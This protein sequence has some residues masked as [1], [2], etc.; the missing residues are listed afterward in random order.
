MAW[1]P[2]PEASTVRILFLT[3]SFNSLAQRLYV[4]LAARGHELSVEL[5]INDVATESAAALFRPQLIVAPFLK[6]AIPESVWGRHVC[7]VVHPGI[8]GDR[9][10]SAL[11]WAILEGKTHWGVTVLQ[12]EREMDAGPVWA[13]REFPMRCAPKSSLYRFEVTEA[14]VAAVLEA[15]ER[16]AGG[17]F[18]PEPVDPAD[19]EI[20]GRWRE[21][22]KQAQRTIDWARDDTVTVLRKIHSADGYP[23]VRDELAGLPVRLYDTHPEGRLA[24][25][26]GALLARRDGAVCRATVDGAVWIGRLRRTD[27]PGLKL[28][29]VDVLGEVGEA[30]PESRLESGTPLDYPTYREIRYEERKDVGFLHFDFHNGAMG[31]AQCRRLLEAWRHAR[32]RPTRVIVLLGGRDFW[33][34]G[35]HLNLIEAAPSPAD[36]SWHNINAMDDLAEAVVRTDGQLTISALGANAGAGGAFLAL[37]ADR[38]IARE[39]IVLNPH[40]KNMGNLYGSELWTYLLPR[41]VGAAGVAAVMAHRLPLAAGEA[42][43]MGVVDEVGPGDPA[44]F[45]GAVASSAAKL[46]AGPDFAALLAA[47]RQRRAADEGLKPLADYRAEELERMKL[48]F[49]GFDP[50]YHVARYR[51]VHRTPHAWTPL[52]LAAHRRLGWQLPRDDAA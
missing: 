49:Y 48:N 30:L 26:P 13:W 17:V 31:T 25:P 27:E 45:R 44:A 52:Y 3:H 32:A 47:K 43:A 4:E 40:Y 9:G 8:R 42:L 41:R 14:A 50:S 51:F 7:L 37:A 29:A 22:V 39:G 36:E 20:R 10:P 2:A 34:N 18:R 16:F 23:G 24:G 1:P 11:D 28:P 21:S 38:V 35:L 5:D 19:P 46:A 12:A 6:R 15:V 33:S